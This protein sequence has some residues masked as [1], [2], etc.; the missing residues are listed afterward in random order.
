MDAMVSHRFTFT[1]EAASKLPPG[2]YDFAGP[3]IPLFPAIG[4]KITLAGLESFVFEV[5]QRHFTIR[6]ES[7]EITYLLDFVSHSPPPSPDLKVVE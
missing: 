5:A 2:G 1:E 6:E 7:V 3:Q 4:D